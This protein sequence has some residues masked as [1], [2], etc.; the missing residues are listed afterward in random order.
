MNSN[1]HQ[2]GSS[3]TDIVYQRRSSKNE[4][5]L[6]QCVCVKKPPCTFHTQR[7]ALVINTTQANIPNAD[8]EFKFF[9]FH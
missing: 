4:R 7:N 8:S 5:K 9:D 1:N 6:T 2:R 3:W